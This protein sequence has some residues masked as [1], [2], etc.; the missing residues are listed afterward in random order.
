MS[1]NTL[2]AVFANHEQ[3]ERAIK[4]LTAVNF[5][6]KQLSIIGQGYHT[7][8]NVVG[9]YNTGDR[10]KF[11]G[12][13]GAFWGGLWGLFFGGVFLMVPIIGQVMVLGYV[14]T[15]VASAV[16]GAVVAGGLGVLGAALASV[17][18]AKDSVI[19]YEMAL[20][21]DAFLVTAHGSDAEL[22][23]ARTILAAATPSSLELHS[24]ATTRALITAY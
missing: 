2:V 15:V 16:E 8:E 9:F 22:E 14:A 4:D 6:M 1:D 13:R 23:R 5:D 18:V 12:K 11:W 19:R 7:E 17:G 10:I 24:G 20:K 3:A 21:A